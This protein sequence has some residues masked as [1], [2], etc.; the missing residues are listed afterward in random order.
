LNKVFYAGIISFAVLLTGCEQTIV[1][2]SHFPATV[3]N[4]S[5]NKKI[6]FIAGAD[7]H[8]EGE[9]EHKASVELLS[10][11]L[12]QQYPEAEV[13]NI[14][15][16]WPIDDAVLTDADVI[17]I[18]GDGGPLHVINDHLDTVSQLV[19]DGVGFVVLHYAVELARNSAA[20]DVMQ[21]AIGGYFETHWSVNP[22]WQANFTIT[23]SHPIN[24]GIASFSLFDEWYFNM[25]FVDQGVTTILS[26]V[27]PD[28]TMERWNGAHSGNNA[29]REMVKAQQLQTVA[30]AFERNNGGRGVGYTGGHYLTHWDNP[31]TRQLL[32]NAIAWTAGS[33]KLQP[34]E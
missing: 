34:A 5:I 1:D 32:I 11:E 18:Y 9:H 26:A 23:P 21:R 13:V 28:N 8:A 15:G 4:I 33:P 17:V 14:I 16:G 24:E 12:R 22:F 2:V 20:A 30:W 6:V 7:S 25:R 31:N 3:E 27:P 29:V 19:D 10:L